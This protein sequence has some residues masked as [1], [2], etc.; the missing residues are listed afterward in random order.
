MW[1]LPT[2]PSLVGLK[3]LQQRSKVEACFHRLKLLTQQGAPR[4]LGVFISPSL[5]EVLPEGQDGVIT[6]KT[7]GS[8]VRLVAW[9]FICCVTLNKLLN[10][11]ELQ[12]ASCKME[13]IVVY[14]VVV[15]A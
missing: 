9:P 11:S 8:K 7:T 4:M 13:S 15:R 3:S 14:R 12:L 6:N 5:S 10:L 1:E 2:T